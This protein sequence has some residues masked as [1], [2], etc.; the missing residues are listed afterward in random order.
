MLLYE[1]I[2]EEGKSRKEINDYIYPILNDTVEKMDSRVRT[3]LTY[4]KSKNFIENKRTD[5]KP[6]CIKK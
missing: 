1:F 6:I 3:A 2:S 5:T 4:L